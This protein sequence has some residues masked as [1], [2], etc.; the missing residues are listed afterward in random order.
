MTTAVSLANLSVKDIEHLKCTKKIVVLSPQGSRHTETARRVGHYLRIKHN[1]VADVEIKYV[2]DKIDFK[3]SSS[4]KELQPFMIHPLC[5]Y[6][7]DMT[8]TD[9]PGLCWYTINACP[10]CA[11]VAS[12]INAAFE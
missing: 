6:A 12:T 1:I 10:H 5:K 3:L 8:N 9:M 4:P 11:L 2:D 7:D